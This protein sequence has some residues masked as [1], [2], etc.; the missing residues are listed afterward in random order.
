MESLHTDWSANDEGSSA[1]LLLVSPDGIE[2]TYAL[3]FEFKTT[4][5]EAEY[6]ALLAGLTLAR[7][8]K[9]YN[10]QIHVDS[11]C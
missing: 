10:L 8:M 4:K 2:F 11:A 6:E 9:V 3:W 7:K 5:N 1:G